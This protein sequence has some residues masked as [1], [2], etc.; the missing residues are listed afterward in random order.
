MKPQGETPALGEAQGKTSSKAP[1]YG[2]SEEQSEGHA[3]CQDLGRSA[4]LLFLLLA[5]LSTYIA[6]G[7]HSRPIKHVPNRNIQTRLMLWPAAGLSEC[8]RGSALVLL[9]GLLVRSQGPHVRTRVRLYAACTPQ[10]RT[11]AHMPQL[12]AFE[13][14]HFF[15]HLSLP[16]LLSASKRPRRARSFVLLLFLKVGFHQVKL[17]LGLACAVRGRTASRIKSSVL[18]T[19]RL[20]QIGVYYSFPDTSI[21]NRLTL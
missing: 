19:G 5:F 18:S 16:T 15:P 14:G 2:A 17:R 20:L 9:Q 13:D 6:L 1:K 12:Q 7:F 8:K 11:C 3:A 4:N 21:H 10:N